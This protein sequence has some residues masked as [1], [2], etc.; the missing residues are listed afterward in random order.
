MAAASLEPSIFS[1]FMAG[2]SVDLG[3]S[4]SAL[5]LAV[6]FRLVVAGLI[7]AVAVISLGLIQH[8]WVLY[9]AEREAKNNTRECRGTLAPDRKPRRA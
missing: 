2:M 4:R 1:F 9:R 5:S 7:G 6:M 3:V 8:L